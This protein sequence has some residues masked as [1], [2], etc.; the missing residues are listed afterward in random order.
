M[1][2][3]RKSNSKLLNLIISLIAFVWIFPFLF[4]LFNSVKSGTEYNLGNFW[5]LPKAISLGETMTF[6][7]SRIAINSAMLNSIIYGVVGASLAIL[8]SSLAAYGVTKLPIKGKFYW[9]LLIYSGTIFP[10]QMYLVPVYRA[11][12]KIGLYD[13]KIGMILF[14]MAISIPFCT[15][16][17]RNFFGSVENELLEAARMDG[18][19]DFDIFRKIMLPMAKAPISALFLFQFSFIWNDLLFGLTFS[20][21]EYVR[22]IMPSLSN[23]A[24][25]GGNTTNTPALLVSCIIASI[26]TILIYVLLNK[27]FEEGFVLGG[28]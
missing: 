20:K 26:P 3:I 16:V 7:L 15:F 6:I 23:L 19:T 22:P 5:D 12:L 17:L 10:F 27:N 2:R 8:L 4:V 25:A 11:Y 21:S 13:T 24:G 1:N 28:K 18:G 14:Y 9:F